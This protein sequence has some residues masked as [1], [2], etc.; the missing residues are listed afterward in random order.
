[1]T[2]AQSQILHDYPN[3]KNLFK[4]SQGLLGDANSNA[5]PIFREWIAIP[6]GKQRIGLGDTLVFNLAALGE[7]DQDVEV[8]GLVI[9]KEYF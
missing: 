8:C 4:T 9:Y 2:H 3:K 7:M 6:K 5:V 1:M